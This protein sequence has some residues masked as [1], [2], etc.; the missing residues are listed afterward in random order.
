MT[1]EILPTGGSIVG[2]KI[3]G[4]IETRD[5]RN[6]ATLIEERLK[7]HGPLQVYVEVRHLGGIGP[8]AL[9]EDLRLAFGHFKDFNRK[10]VVCDRGWLSRLADISNRLV[11]GIEVRCFSWDE[12]DAAI[13]WLE[14]N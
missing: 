5:V 11:P 1:M 14:N 2:V 3:D 12:K 10:A 9:W 13:A 4:G 8:E 7:S 6:L